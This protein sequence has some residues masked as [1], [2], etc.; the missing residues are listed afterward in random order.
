MLLVSQDRIFR[1]LLPDGKE[2]TIIEKLLAILKPFAIAT[3]ALNGSSY[4]TISIVY[5]LIYKFYLNLVEKESDG[6]NMRQLFGLI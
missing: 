3:K 6:D 5:P 2:W 1:I 4:A